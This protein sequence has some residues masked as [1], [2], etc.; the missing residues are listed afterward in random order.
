MQYRRASLESD[1]AGLSR[2]L[3]SSLTLL[4]TLGAHKGVGNGWNVDAVADSRDVTTTDLSDTK[5]SLSLGQELMAPGALTGKRT[6]VLL[7]EPSLGGLGR[8]ADLAEFS[9]GENDVRRVS[10]VPL[11]ESAPPLDECGD[12]GLNVAVSLGWC[13]MAFETSAYYEHEFLTADCR[14]ESLRQVEQQ[15][16]V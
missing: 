4:D 12:E 3:W 15:D 2:W 10:G 16:F 14:E 1:T 11:K 9:S 7:A 13:S 8:R 5:G 6:G